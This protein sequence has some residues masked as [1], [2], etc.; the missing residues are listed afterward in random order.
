MIHL[1]LHRG[2]KSIELMSELENDGQKG[3]KRAASLDHRLM[4]TFGIVGT[5]LN[6]PFT[7]PSI[8]RRDAD[9]DWIMLKS[10]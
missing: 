8:L 1:S 5:S 10:R 7:S 2:M 4:V 6:S 9:R 3:V